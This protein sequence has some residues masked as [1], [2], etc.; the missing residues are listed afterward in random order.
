M[1]TICALTRAEE[2][3]RQKYGGGYADSRNARAASVR[4]IK[5]CR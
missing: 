4:S 5:N 2:F 3:L 1:V